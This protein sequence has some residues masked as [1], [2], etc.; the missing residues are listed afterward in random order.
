MR[1]TIKKYYLF[2]FLFFLAAFIIRALTTKSPNTPLENTLIVIGGALLISLTI[3]TLYYFL[4]T[5]WGPSQQVKKLSKSPFKDLVQMGFKQEDN[6]IIG[7]M[8]GYTTIVSYTWH[9]GKHGIRIV[10]LFNPRFS[11]R[12]L[13]YKELIAIEK[14]NKKSNLWKNNSIV[15]TRNS[16]EHI[17]EYSFKAPHYTKVLAKAE[18]LSAILIKENLQPVSPEKNEELIPELEKAIEDEKKKVGK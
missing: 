7:Q 3:G 18:E 12:F 13:T 4:D 11:D 14:R 2:P 6:F 17:I 9:T 8:N 5:R 16:I 15:V 1:S 10:V